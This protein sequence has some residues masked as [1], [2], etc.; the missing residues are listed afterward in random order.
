MRSNNHVSFEWGSKNI[1]ILSASRKSGAV[2]IEKALV[3]PM[4]ADSY[5]DGKITNIGKVVDAL[6][7]A[8]IQNQIKH[9][10]AVVTLN[11]TGIIA[12]EILLP[13]VK[14]A[15]LDRMVQYESQRFL[16]A[17]AGLYIIQYR[18]LEKIEEN[19]VTKQKVTVA[20]MP[21]DIVAGSHEVL[22][23]LKLNSTA[24]DINSNGLGRL[25]RP[26]AVLNGSDEITE[27]SIAFFDIGHKYISVNIF[28]NG[29]LRFSRIMEGGG[30]ELNESLME[31]HDFSETEAEETKHQIVDINDQSPVSNTILGVIEAWQNKI[32]RIF[33]F[34]ES[35]NGGRVT[36][37][38]LYGGTAALGGISE[39][40]G[41]A[42][43]IP[44]CVVGSVKGLTM[45]DKAMENQCHLFLNTAGILAA[46][47]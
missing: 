11:S 41:T 25:I 21:R 45:S 18:I 47:R 28:T 8:L 40:M 2:C 32:Q 6:S 36:Q 26:G 31:R 10:N 13:V 7:N 23:T 33:Q 27:D 29:I 39:A 12:R 14:P 37:A 17:D 16:P 1:K 35:R 43:N 4:P 5:T 38:Y 3:V 44:I 19:G 24:L 34:Y 20:A 22:K 46:N 9:L 42:L 30:A 15:E